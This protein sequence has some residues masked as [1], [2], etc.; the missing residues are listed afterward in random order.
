MLITLIRDNIPAKAEA[1]G[2]KL[3]ATPA[4]ND[5]L[6]AN[7][8]NERLLDAVS[9]YLSSGNV[10]A[11]VEAQV[12]VDTLT[13]LLGERY[14]ELYDQQIAELGTYSNRYMLVQMQGTAKANNAPAVPTET[15]EVVEN[16][17]AGESN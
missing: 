8:L 9:T 2:V 16:A 6:F 17:P 12:V 3:N 11:L 13:T 4:L 1:E 14:K 5:D 7:L 10:E 15:T